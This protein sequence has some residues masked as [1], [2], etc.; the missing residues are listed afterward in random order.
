[1]PHKCHGN[2][3]NCPSRAHPV[4]ELPINE[5]DRRDDPT[6]DEALPGCHL[7]SS[8]SNIVDPDQFGRMLRYNFERHFGSNR[9]PLGFHFSASW[10]KSN[11]GFK[12]ELEKFI[13]EMIDRND[14]YFVTML[15][16]TVELLVRN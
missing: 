2:G 9:A 12:R 4:W 15:Q 10:I 16:V 6:F 11:K 5:L 14:V 8:C 7:V 13:A 1:M 3:G